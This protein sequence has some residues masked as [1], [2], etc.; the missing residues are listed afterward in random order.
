M[1][2]EK[3]PNAGKFVLPDG[4]TDLGYQVSSRNNTTVAACRAAEHITR[5]FDNS[6]YRYRCTDVITLC[7][8]CKT[9]R[10]TDMSD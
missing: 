4:Y 8:E 7:D 2:L 10:H 1:R 6:L 9:I 3:N 5:E